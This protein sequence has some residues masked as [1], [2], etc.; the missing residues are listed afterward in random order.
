MAVKK[1]KSRGRKL[2]DAVDAASKGGDILKGRDQF[3][4]PI[5]KKKK[6]K[7]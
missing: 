4:R 7:K 1:K 5:K 6:K 2:T 3:G